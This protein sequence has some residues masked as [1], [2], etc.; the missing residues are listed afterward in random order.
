VVVSLTGDPHGIFD[1]ALAKYEHSRRVALTVP[2]FMQALALIAETELVAA[3]PRRLVAIHAARF[4]LTSTEAPL[5]LR[6]D[7]IRAIV[8]RAAMT[9]PSVAWLFGLLQHPVT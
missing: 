1:E 4:G 9:D 5:P 6:R 3:L 2:N 8:T 7:K